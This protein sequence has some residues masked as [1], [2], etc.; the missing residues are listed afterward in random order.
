MGYVEVDPDTRRM[1][2]AIATRYAQPHFEEQVL[3]PLARI[4]RPEV[5]SIDGL[6]AAMLDPIRCLR[7]LLGH[8]A[9][10][11]RGKERDELSSIAVEALNRWICSS[12]G[13][14]SEDNASELWVL[15]EQVC[16]ERHKKPHPQLNLG[17]IAGIAEL[18]QEIYRLNGRGSIAEWVLD[19]V[20]ETGRLEP[21]F[22]RMVDVR[23][24]GPKLTSLFLRDVILLFELEDGVDHADRLFLQPIDK[25]MRAIAPLL[26]EEID[27]DDTADWVLAGKVAKYCRYSRVSGVAFNMGVSYFGTHVVRSADRIEDSLDALFETLELEG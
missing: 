25:W 10:Y 26:I 13:F 20:T 15:F 27:A 11:R 9:F 6:R 4:A 16:Q 18:A 12:P 8:Y 23:G 21:E 1:M 5:R 3:A 2:S 19:A 24:V 17:V 7:T 22:L 14:L